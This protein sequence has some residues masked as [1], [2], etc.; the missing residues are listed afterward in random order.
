MFCF[1]YLESYFP[2]H[3]ETSKVQL[4]LEALPFPPVS[5]NPQQSWRWMASEMHPFPVAQR[6]VSA[7]CLS[8]PSSSIAGTAFWISGPPHH[9]YLHQVP[10]DAGAVCAGCDALLIT[11]L[12][13]DAGHGGLVLLQ[14]LLQLLGLVAYVPHP[15]L[16]ATKHRLSVPTW[17]F[18]MKNRSQECSHLLGLI[19][20]SN[21]LFSSWLS[22]VG[23]SSCRAGIFFHGAR[24]TPTRSLHPFL[25]L[26]LRNL[27]GPRC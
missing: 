16:E 20:F 23:I 2:I 7:L 12:H 27:P 10:D 3:Q 26:G 8:F 15:H 6:Q 19:C 25:L 14:C 18:L 11:L 9:W 22:G 4:F 5:V 1:V 17:D 21:S 24:K 13:P